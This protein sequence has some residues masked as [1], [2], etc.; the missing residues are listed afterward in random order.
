VSIGLLY[1]SQQTIQSNTKGKSAMTHRTVSIRLA[2]ATTCAAAIVISTAMAVTVSHAVGSPLITPAT[3]AGDF[4]TPLDSTPNP[5]ADTIYFTAQVKNGK[6]KGVFTV[7]AKG[8]KA[9]VLFSG[10]P[11]TSPAGIAMSL[12]G[13]Q[14]FVADAG[15]NGI[16]SMNADGTGEPA[17][18]PGTQSTSPR[19]LD[20]VS[21]RDQMTIYYTGQDARD[22]QPAVFK[23]SVF[24]ATQ[25]AVV[26]KGT[27]LV[28]PDGVAVGPNGTVYVADRA[29]A[30]KSMGKVFT[31]TSDK[32]AVLVENV[33]T[34]KPAGIALTKDGSTLLVS[35][36][37]SNSKYDQVLVVNTATGASSIV[38]DVV[39]LNKDAGGIHRAHNLN[40][41]SWCGLTAGDTGRVYRV[42]P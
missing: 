32:I 16:F 17:L 33:H 3:L 15:A 6:D 40:V 35:S 25:P 36:Y 21:E 31:I 14:I 28:D 1:E 26:F 13:R 18:I 7:P 8:G 12:D 5:N 23:I 38:T 11:F 24:G 22:G 10:A 20:V 2:R 30:G 34:G 4:R 39:G 29:A 19:N 9:T 37:Q 42:S 27:P 41:F